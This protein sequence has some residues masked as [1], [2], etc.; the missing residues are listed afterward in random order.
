MCSYIRAHARILYLAATVAGSTWPF[1]ADLLESTFVVYVGWCPLRRLFYIGKT[2]DFMARLRR[3]TYG[4]LRPDSAHPQPYMT[5]LQALSGGDPAH[6]LSSLIFI[7]VSRCFTEEAAA[8]L[9]RELIDAL[10]PPLNEPYVQKL[11][12]A[13]AARHAHRPTRTVSMSVGCKPA[14]SLA[15]MSSSKSWS[16]F[17]RSSA[18]RP[19]SRHSTAHQA[20]AACNTLGKPASGQGRRSLFSVLPSEWFTTWCFIRRTFEGIPRCIGL[21]FMDRVRKFRGWPAPCMSVFGSLPWT[22]SRLTKSILREA[23][24]RMINSARGRGRVLLIPGIRK[25]RL[26][27]SERPAV[28]MKS[29]LRNTPTFYT[30]VTS[31]QPCICHLYPDLPRLPSPDGHSHVFAPQDA[32]PWPAELDFLRL[33]PCH[34][35]VVPS[36]PFIQRSCRRLLDRVGS[37]LGMPEDTPAVAAHAESMAEAIFSSMAAAELDFQPVRLE[38]VHAA[39]ALVKGLVVEEFQKTK[40]TLVAECPRRAQLLTLRLFGADGSDPSLWTS[41]TSRRT[42]F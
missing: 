9:E 34:T 11:L 29:A 31:T 14:T 3:H 42:L 12:S 37:R 16:V 25:L 4:F 22:P 19:N 28:T 6:A 32:W 15:R 39:K 41:I 24:A 2:V 40:H 27:I 8:H 1:S 23:L 35:A 33:L 7:P 38:H 10:H 13:A 17:C 26:L 21:R 36:R 20:A 5:L 18:T 30:N